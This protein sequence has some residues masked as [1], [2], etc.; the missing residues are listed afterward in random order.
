MLYCV[1]NIGEI[2]KPKN[3]R[4]TFFIYK[5]IQI[6]ILK[7]ILSSCLLSVFSVL[8]ATAL[9]YLFILNQYT[10]TQNY[11]LYQFIT[12]LRE[13]KTVYFIYVIL[14]LIFSAGLIVYSW[15]K[16]SHKIAGPLYQMR[17]NLNQYVETNQ[18]EFIPISL[19]KDDEMQDLA[20]SMNAAI[21]KSGQKGFSLIEVLVVIGL[22]AIIAAGISSMLT[23][24]M[25]QQK[26]LQAKDQQ[27]EVT[28][29]IRNLLNKK[30]ACGFSF[31]GRNP[32][33]SGFDVPAI[34]DAL[35]VAQYNV[36][37]LDK[38]GQLR[39]EKFAVDNWVPDAGFTTQGR[40]DLK[41][42][43]SKVGDTG[44]V[45]NIRPDVITLKIKRDAAGNISECFSLGS[46]TDSV[47]QISPFNP[48]NIYYGGGNVGIKNDNPQA[49]LQ[50][51][52]TADANVSFFA[53]GDTTNG[54]KGVRMHYNNNPAHPSYEWSVIDSR[55]R[56]FALRG[57]SPTVGGD[58]G[59]FTEKL[60]INLANGNV[61]IGTTNP[62]VPLDVSGMIR[63][64][65]A[66]VG[67]ACSVKGGQAY[68]GATGSPLYCNGTNWLAFGLSTIAGVNPTCPGGPSSEFLK[69]WP[70]QAVPVPGVP[71]GCSTPAGW[72]G[73]PPICEGC[74]NFEQCHFGY[75]TSWNSII[76]R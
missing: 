23:S 50:I 51:G 17:Q 12:L 76:C 25:K 62:Q 65:A 38:T 47:W 52:S 46:Q 15:L 26:G 7:V 66:A 61:G 36:G 63:P 74:N 70:A 4:R 22:F 45:K 13:F 2:M 19:R 75:A 57:V 37:A 72:S 68:D 8:S 33:P 29:E 35:G 60:V 27:R 39:F 58:A 9:F 64:M 54:E 67:N 34:N 16:L 55:A 48:S 49:Q 3:R 14:G 71:A 42:E 44:S 10:E 59:A 18:A 21:A 73:T 5:P 43:L 11:Q 30:A 6:L 69:Y 41:I 20:L 56:F 32:Q 31:G 40:A 1:T 53:L 28:A 24:G